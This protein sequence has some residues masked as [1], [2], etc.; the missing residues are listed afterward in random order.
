MGSILRPVNRTVSGPPEAKRLRF[1]IVLRHQL[2]DRFL[3][4]FD[5]LSRNGG[6]ASAVVADVG[7]P[8]ELDEVLEGLGNLGVEVV[9]VEPVQ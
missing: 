6:S 8:R 3:S 4:S 7:G 9:T 5:R 1:L 2:S